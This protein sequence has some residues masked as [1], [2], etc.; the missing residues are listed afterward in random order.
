MHAVKVL[1]TGPMMTYKKLG[2]TTGIFSS[3]CHTHHT[4]IMVLRWGTGFAN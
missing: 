3:V 1:R 4:P 2:T